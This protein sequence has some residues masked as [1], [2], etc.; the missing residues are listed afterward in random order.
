[1]AD[2]IKMLDT[3]LAIVANLIKG[4]GTEP[5]WVAWGTGTTEASEQDVDME[6]ESSEEGRTTGTSSTAT[7]TT[8]GDTYR[9]IASITCLSTSK[10]ITEVGIFDALTSGNMFM[11]ATFDA[12]NVNAADS[13]Q[14]TIN[15]VLAQA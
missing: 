15:T 14:F 11:R 10:A 5:N 6:L 2:V 13:I 1:M 4:S 7:T 12:I 3:G 9:V 8:A